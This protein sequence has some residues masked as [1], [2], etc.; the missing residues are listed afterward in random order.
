[1]QCPKTCNSVCNFGSVQFSV[2][3]KNTCNS[4]KHSVFLHEFCSDFLHC[5]QIEPKG[6]TLKAEIGFMGGDAN[7]PLTSP[8]KEISDQCQTSSTRTKIENGVSIEKGVSSGFDRWLH[9]YKGPMATALASP[10]PVEVRSMFFV[11]LL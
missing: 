2:Q 9:W 7:F 3:F 4:V 1:M 11:Q 8:T 10:I 6:F 5:L